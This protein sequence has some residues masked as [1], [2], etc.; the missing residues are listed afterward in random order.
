MNIIFSWIFSSIAFTY[1]LLL[2]LTII[3]LIYE[4]F[5]ILIRLR[6]IMIFYSIL[7]FS[8]LFAPIFVLYIYIWNIIKVRFKIISDNYFS[9]IILTFIWSLICSTTIIILNS[10]IMRYFLY[11]IIFIIFVCIW[12]GTF[13][14]RVLIKR[15]RPGNIDL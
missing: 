15:L 4:P 11:E 10:L 6:N 13:L 3:I 7:V 2:I 9:L 8:F 14:P 1:L 12:F 5:Y